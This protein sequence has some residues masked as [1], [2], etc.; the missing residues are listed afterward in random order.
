V[1]IEQ[2]LQALAYS[3]VDTLALVQGAAI[4]AGA[5]L[6]VACRHRVG[7]PDVQ[8]RF[9]GARFGLILGSRRLAHCVGGEVAAGLIGSPEK[10]NAARMK[11]IG[12]LNE[13]LEPTQWPQRIHQILNQVNQVSPEN[14]AKVLQLLNVDTRAHDMADL[15]ASASQSD[16]KKHIRTFLDPSKA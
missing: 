2:M 15:V 9:P 13:L 3:P 14:R 10:I 8:S 4:G 16:L 1:R 6:L 7:A 11:E 12:L 5:D